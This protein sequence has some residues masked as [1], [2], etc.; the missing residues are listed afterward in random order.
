MK[1]ELYYSIWL[2]CFVCSR[3]RYPVSE[4]HHYHVVHLRNLISKVVFICFESFSLDYFGAVATVRDS[5]T[6][7][8]SS[9]PVR[10]VVAS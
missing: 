8:P 6:D 4:M 7:D 10:S 1:F 5:H 9:I 2:V 3:Q